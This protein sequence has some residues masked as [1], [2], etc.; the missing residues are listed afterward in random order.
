[1]RT[2]TS[3]TGRLFYV[4]ED[5]NSVGTIIHKARHKW[6]VRD[7]GGRVLAIALNSKQA[8]ETAMRVPFPT[9]MQVHEELVLDMID[10]R[11]AAAASY[12]G[13][14]IAA[15]ATATLY[16]SSVG[17]SDLADLLTAVD[18]FAVERMELAVPDAVFMQIPCVPKTLRK[19]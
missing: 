8:C 3:G 15:A 11:R 14:Q 5:G 2:I 6:H 18:Q 10:R 12:L 13:P 7:A 1:M 4:M 9:P 19:E 16:G 17:R